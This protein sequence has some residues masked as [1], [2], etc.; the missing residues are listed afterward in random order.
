MSQ[1]ASR[2]I[3]Q[4]EKSTT[5]DLGFTGLTK[6][7]NEVFKLTQLKE[8]RLSNRRRNK[9]NKKWINSDN[10]NK[11]QRNNSISEIPPE[12]VKLKNLEILYI[13]GSTDLQK[14]TYNYD[15]WQISNISYIKELKKLSHLDLYDNDISDISIIGELPELEYINLGS[16]H[17]SDI[18]GLDKLQK[19][20][21]ID[22]SANHISDISPI[23][24]LIEL[25]RLIL[26]TNN[27]SDISALK[28]MK[29]LNALNLSYNKISDILILE[30]LKDTL[31]FLSLT[32]NSLLDISVLKKN[33]KL[34]ALY[35]RDNEQIKDFSVLQ[36]LKN[37]KKLFLRSNNISDIKFLERLYKLQ[38]LELG[39]NNISDISALKGLKKLAALDISSNN[40]ISDISILEGLTK[41]STLN[42]GSNSQ[43]KDFS[44]VKKLHNLTNLDISS[45]E[46]SDISLVESL[47][48]LQKVNISNNKIKDVAPL[49]ELKSMTTLDI[50]H[51]EIED[52]SQLQKNSKLDFLDISFNKVRDISTFGNLNELKHINI[53]HNEISD[54]SPLRSLIRKSN[55]AITFGNGGID[56]FGCPINTPPLEIIRRGREPIL[57]YF[58]E[59]D[60]GIAYLNEAKLL[61]VGEGS[62]GKTSLCYKLRDEKADLPPEME[63]TRG[64]DVIRLKIHGKNNKPFYINVWDFGGQDVYHFVHQFFLTQRSLYVLLTDTRRQDDNF[65]YWIPN[66]QLFGGDSPIVIVNNHKHGITRQVDI[67]DFGKNNKFNIQGN[68]CEVNLK[69]GD[70]FTVLRD[71][72]YHYIQQLPLVGGLI[73]E[74]WVKVREELDL[75]KQKEAHISYETFKDVCNRNGIYD[76]SKIKDLC[77]YLHDLGILLWYD[78]I[79]LK[80]SIILQP[81]W[82]TDAVYLIIDDSIVQ[83]KHGHFDYADIKRIWASQTYK[84]MHDELIAL[85]KT[86]N[87][88]YQKK[89]QEAYIIP[90][91]LP[92]NTNIDWDESDNVRLYYEYEFMPK[93]IVSQLTTELHHLIS[94]D[95]KVSRRSVVFKREGTLVRV[96]EIRK[97]KRLILH[98]R[99]KYNILPGI[100]RPYRHYL[101]YN[102]PWKKNGLL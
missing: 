11:G 67:S 26:H 3:K 73:P 56:I 4:A 19:L 47:K 70:G 84:N 27:I 28:N 82:A 36:S 91:M 80:K 15:K 85:M 17:I 31:T 89:Y 57:R 22:L 66:I 95:R 7:P 33:H 62:V 86:F 21:D 32:A 98:A 35:L 99:G 23:G 68:V 81:T 101:Y 53:S 49:Q 97:E 93:G 44:V 64:I 77:R 54:I 92:L 9:K 24:S 39:L 5:L 78:T 37:L 102:K 45:N 75:K 42:I 74:S 72:I 41:I 29:K 59:I 30:S 79:E 61:I 52:V 38:E 48:N 6:I 90:S 13:G 10:A 94:D 83:E 55:I 34:R 8:L 60:K 71:D 12:I 96:E 58:D 63:P 100:A 76:P 87:L 1:L 65:H 16:N 69:S 40:T 18:T 43:I 2:L 88:C 46:I 25:T 50:S 14:D 20:K 51:N